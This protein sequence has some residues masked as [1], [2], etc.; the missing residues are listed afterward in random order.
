[1]FYDNPFYWFFYDAEDALAI[2]IVIFVFVAIFF[3]FAT[4]AKYYGMITML[5]V[6]VASIALYCKGSDIMSRSHRAE[7]RQA[8][9]DRGKKIKYSPIALILA[10]LFGTF[11]LETPPTIP[12]EI[13]TEHFSKVMEGDDIFYFY[14]SNGNSLKEIKLSKKAFSELEIREPKTEDDT[15]FVFIPE[16]YNKTSNANKLVIFISSDNPIDSYSKETKPKTVK[17]LQ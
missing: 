17:D 11:F 9:N 4:I 1:M 2:M 3:I 13:T 14:S 15:K 6:I 5:V 7:N 10:L 8:E 12:S 16:K